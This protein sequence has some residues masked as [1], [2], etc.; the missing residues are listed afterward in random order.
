VKNRHVESLGLPISIIVMGFYNMCCWRGR[1]LTTKEIN[2]Q[3]WVR[4]RSRAKVGAVDD[5]L[6]IISQDL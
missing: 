5:F 6:G 1:S 2:M 4:G 3:V